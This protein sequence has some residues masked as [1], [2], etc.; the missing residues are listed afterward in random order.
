MVGSAG[1]AAEL[2]T[3]RELGFDVFDYHDGRVADRL[4]A[5][6]GNAK[7]THAPVR[8]TTVD[9]VVTATGRTLKVAEWGE[10]AGRPVFFLHGTPSSRL[11][12]CL[13]P[14]ALAGVRLV[15]YD[16]PGYGESDPNP[17]RTVA[18]VAADVATIADAL[19][20]GRF[21]VYG[22][23]GGGP[24]A[25]A[26]AALL[27]DRV[28]RAASLSGLAPYDVLGS[29]WTDGMAESNI[30][31]IGAA[32]AGPEVLAEMLAPQRAAILADPPSLVEDLA[33]ELPPPDSDLL[34][35]P[36]VAAALTAEFAE[37]V[38]SS[39]A[40]WIDDD[41]AFTRSWGFDPAAI[42]VPVLIWHGGRDKLVPVAHATALAGL[43]PHATAITDPDAGHLSAIDAHPDTLSWLLA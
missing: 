43:V 16:R 2:A 19:G 9:A 10:P 12:R 37:S 42:T 5:R 41:L 40:G 23:S 8:L 1:T 3:V 28:E 36:D 14:A 39:T 13:H 22:A 38:R 27:P 11:E 29:A 15:T 18:D 35:R 6:I 20:L 24:H 31:E 30:T 4:L 21:A 7:P 32:V 25:L 26:C 33:A 34:R 17:G